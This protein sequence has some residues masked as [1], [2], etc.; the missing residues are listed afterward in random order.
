MYFSAAFT[1]PLRSPP[2][3]SEKPPPVPPRQP[4]DYSSLSISQS[5]SNSRDEGSMKQASAEL[6]HK[7]SPE[8]IPP[9]PPLSSEFTPPSATLPRSL[10]SSHTPVAEAKFVFGSVKDS[11]NNNSVS[12]TQAP[13]PRRSMIESASSHEIQDDN[14]RASSDA[15]K[16]SKSPRPP[17]RTPLRSEMGSVSSFGG[18]SSSPPEIPARTYKSAATM[19]A[20]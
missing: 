15:S 5:R 16:F 9:R 3:R 8:K 13:Y 1:Y 19:S 12:M 10:P 17:P 2:S 20:S 7:G 4:L 6:V 18:T 14:S 11:D